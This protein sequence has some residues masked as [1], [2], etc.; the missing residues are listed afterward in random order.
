MKRFL[1]TVCATL[2]AGF[3]FGVTFA[4]K[5]YVDRAISDSFSTSNNALV[6][7]IQTVA[8]QE[9]NYSAVS[10]YAMR[11]VQPRTSVQFTGIMVAPYPSLLGGSSTVIESDRVYVGKADVG[12]E[13]GGTSITYYDYFDTYTIYFPK[14]TGT[15][16]VDSALTNYVINIVSN[17]VDEGFSDW[18]I[19]REGVDVTQRVS[20][21]TWNENSEYWDIT[22]SVVSGDMD[23]TYPS[24]SSNAVS[25]TWEAIDVGADEYKT[26]TATRSRL[27]HN[28]L[29][30]ARIT[31]LP[32]LTNDIPSA[33]AA[34][35]TA[36]SNYTD[37]ALGD[38]A[39]TGAVQYLC[40]MDESEAW[41]DSHVYM[42]IDTSSESLFLWFPHFLSFIRFPNW[43]QA[44]TIAETKAAQAISSADTTYTRFSISAPTNVN[45]S[46]QHINIT[47][48]N[49]SV[50]SVIIPEGTG[51]KDWIIYVNS[52]TNVTINLPA[53]TW[54]LADT[55]TTNDIA[56]Q[57]PT[58]LYFSQAADNIYTMGRQEFTEIVL[59]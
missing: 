1:L 8:P 7:T 15:A 40:W 3:A 13:Y 25:I 23:D 11:A 28:I 12:S 20:Q 41:Q 39:T 26:Y 33:I 47:D 4:P 27:T 50:L 10:N 16:V 48:E 30:L 19:F 44:E 34:S 6:S 18:T 9:G 14:K 57:T 59:P 56:P 55:S 52:R 43:W 21:P 51:T 37:S 54:W 22:S 29:G 24:G 36:S 46:V 38:F 58:A 42:K 17:E 49:P 35:A 53:A 2:L 45:Q 31:D 32:S 5:E